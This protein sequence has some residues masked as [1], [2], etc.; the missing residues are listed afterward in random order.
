MGSFFCVQSKTGK[1]LTPC[2]LAD[3][4]FVY[5]CYTF[6]GRKK[7]EGG[8]TSGQAAAGNFVAGRVRC[9]VA[10]NVVIRKSDTTMFFV[11]MIY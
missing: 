5:I 6:L 10:I 2:F 4:S 8:I 1:P 11:C 7:V 3:Y 9:S